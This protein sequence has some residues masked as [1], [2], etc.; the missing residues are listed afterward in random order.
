MFLYAKFLFPIA[1]ILALVAGAWGIHHD[2]VKRGKALTQVSF[3]AY[4][5]KVAEVAALA[6]AK[7]A[8]KE[9]NAKENNANQISD[10]QRKLADSD[11]FG[12]SLSNQLRRAI[13]KAGSGG[14]PQGPDQPGAVGSS[15]EKQLVEIADAVG[16]TA[17]E[18]RNNDDQLDALIL[19]IKPQA[20]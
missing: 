17:A 14:V 7:A 9:K 12:K 4:V 2:G 18:C 19:E 13:A 11:A 5:S 1:I 20:L 8:E 15:Q 10:F 3:D 16:N 6:S